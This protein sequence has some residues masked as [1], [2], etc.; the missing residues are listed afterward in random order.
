MIKVKCDYTA[1]QLNGR[2][3][4][5]WRGPNGRPVSRESVGAIRMEGGRFEAFQLGELVTI[6]IDYWDSGQKLSHLIDVDQESAYSI[7][8]TDDTP[9]TFTVG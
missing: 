8:V 5:F 2:R 1:D 4:V 9:E 7:K 6:R 3:V